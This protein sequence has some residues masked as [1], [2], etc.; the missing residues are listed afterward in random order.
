MKL[1][2]NRR[3]VEEQTYWMTYSC[4]RRQ[5]LEFLLEFFRSPLAHILVV[6]PNADPF[7][8]GCSTA[9]Q[10]GGRQRATDVERIKRER[11]PIRD[12]IEMTSRIQ[13]T[14]RALSMIKRLLR[15]PGFFRRSVSTRLKGHSNAPLRRVHTRSRYTR[16]RFLESQVSRWSNSSILFKYCRTDFGL[17]MTRQFRFDAKLFR[18][19][20]WTFLCF[21]SRGTLGCV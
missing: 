14:K 11:T 5:T 2:T 17:V 3:N 13:N 12:R 18:N 7:T 4:W 1:R 6:A 8:I 15:V 10:I 21:K 9:S 19:E 20:F 16:K